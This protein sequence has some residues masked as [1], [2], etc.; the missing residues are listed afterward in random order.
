MKFEI[1]DDGPKTLAECWA[2][3]RGSR[4]RLPHRWSKG[5]HFAGRWRH[6]E[7]EAVRFKHGKAG[8][9][10]IVVLSSVETFEDTSC[11]HVR[12]YRGV[13]EV[14]TLEMIGRVRRDFRLGNDAHEQGNEKPLEHIRS[15]WMRRQPSN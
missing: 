8:P 15:I 10:Q 13:R 7:I 1:K 14:A 12:V 2:D 3:W 6:E 9:D 4:P 11:Y 5:W